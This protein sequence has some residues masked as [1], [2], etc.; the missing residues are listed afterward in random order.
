MRFEITAKTD[1]ILDGQRAV[2]KGDSFTIN[3]PSGAVRPSTLMTP[4]YRD[5][6]VRQLRNQGVPMPPSGYWGGGYWNVKVL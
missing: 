6:A 2:H 1:M 3:I 5:D 4:A